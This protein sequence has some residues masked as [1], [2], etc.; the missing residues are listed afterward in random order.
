VIA[1]D[2]FLRWLAAEITAGRADALEVDVGG[3][4]ARHDHAR[5]LTIRARTLRRIPSELAA[6]TVGDGDPIV[7]ERC[8]ICD[9]VLVMKV[10][11]VAMRFTP[12]DTDP[13]FCR[14][15]TIYR[16]RTL[17]R[18]VATELELIDHARAAH[19]RAAAARLIYQR[20][21]GDAFTPCDLYMPP[22]DGQSTSCERCEY[23]GEAHVTRP[24]A[25]VAAPP[26][27]FDDADQRT[28]VELAGVLDR[29]LNGRHRTAV[30][31][32]AVERATARAVEVV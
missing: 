32:I 10:G 9:T 5:E 30:E 31:R 11:E 4:T 22:A 13:A 23:I 28:A 15:L 19:A 20:E 17:E 6:I 1:F 12:H 26:G 2:L 21:R 7:L 25:I 24:I 3:F 16:L 29:H 8:A 14:D 18:A 27:P